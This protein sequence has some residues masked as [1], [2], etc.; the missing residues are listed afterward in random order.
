M[1]NNKHIFKFIAN[2]LMV[3]GLLAGAFFYSFNE[4]FAKKCASSSSVK[5]TSVKENIPNAAG[6][7]GPPYN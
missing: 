3:S 4:A 7:D 1:I 5:T 6:V 2:G